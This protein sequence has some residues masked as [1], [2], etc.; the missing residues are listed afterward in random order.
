M[1]NTELINEIE[2]AR[3]E[4]L[5]RIKIL[6]SDRYFDEIQ[7]IV[8]NE[9]CTYSDAWKLIEEER[10]SLNLRPRYT[11]RESFY[12]TLCKRRYVDRNFRK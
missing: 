5:D 2:Q 8:W 1:S 10:A 11:S 9:S 4:L 12:N 7:Q 6:E 3:Q